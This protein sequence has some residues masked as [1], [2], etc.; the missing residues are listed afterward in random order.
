MHDTDDNREKVAAGGLE[1]EVF[2]D[3]SFAY[4]AQ[5]QNPITPVILKEY[6]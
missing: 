5:P 4:N 3:A 6:L 2:K 1:E